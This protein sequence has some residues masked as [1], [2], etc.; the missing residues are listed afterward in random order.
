MN[1]QTSAA[2]QALRRNKYVRHRTLK[3]GGTYRQFQDADWPWLWAAYR[4][5]GL[6]DFITEAIRL[7]TSLPEDTDPDSLTQEQFRLL[8]LR[9]GQGACGVWMMTAADGRPVGI[10][11]AYPE[12]LVTQKPHV[13]WFPWASPRNRLECALRFVLKEGK[14]SNLFLFTKPEDRK[15]WQVLCR[16]GVLRPIGKVYNHYEMGDTVDTWQSH[17]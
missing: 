11:M 2:P 13:R 4:K 7:T 1:T 17:R 12:T 14:K 8:M 3:R 9:T 5:G 16:Y 6:S 15:F 10:V